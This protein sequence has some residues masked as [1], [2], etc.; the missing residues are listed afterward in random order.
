MGDP[1]ED[2]CSKCGTAFE[3]IIRMLKDSPVLLALIGGICSYTAIQS[4]ATATRQEAVDVKLDE[5]GAAIK[6][7]QEISQQNQE[8]GKKIETTT[9]A[10]KVVATE[11]KNLVSP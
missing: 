8:I 4:H 2:P 1:V 11:T 10:T 7:T 5:H 9:E 6:K 3:R